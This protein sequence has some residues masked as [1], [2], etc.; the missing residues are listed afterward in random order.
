MSSPERPP[1]P[2]PTPE[3]P[4]AVAGATGE[5]GGAVARNLLAR[6]L[7]VRA[8]VRNPDSDRAR[9]LAS[10]GAELRAADFEDDTS[11]RDAS[12]GTS[13]VFAMASPTPEGGV[14]AEAEH[15]KAIV[16]AVADVG[17]GHV[18]YSSVGGVDRGTGIPHFESKHEIE[19]ALLEL[20]VPATFI[21]P[22]FFME[23]FT[24]FM[25]PTEEDG[26]LVLRMPMP[27]DVPLQMI[28]VT[29]VA[30][31]SVTALLDPS[32]VPDGAIE[33]AGDELTVEHAASALGQRQGLPAR[34][35]ALPTDMLD[36]DNKAMFEW[37]AT[38]PAYQ[39]DLAATR[40]LIP[41]A[42]TFVRWL[43][44]VDLSPAHRAG[45]RA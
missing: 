25:V 19:Q 13:A 38:P 42:L 21:R 36:D 31:G 33:L 45:R 12:A 2:N 28:A 29:D 27:G 16:R 35:E 14:A 37:F 22:T 24:R 30:A 6:G 8:L 23:N 20:G 34:Y 41:D 32:L 40:R 10:A 9:A 26:V 18:V 43:E 7:P 1:A 11:L 4:I 15:G 3:R 44:T 17:V 39:A 5:Q